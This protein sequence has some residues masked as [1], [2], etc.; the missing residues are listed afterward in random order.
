MERQLLKRMNKIK[1]GSEN[2][3]DEQKASV[4]S[5]SVWRNV[6]YVCTERKRNREKNIQ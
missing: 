4:R 3:K 2:D 1:G 5:C 6:I